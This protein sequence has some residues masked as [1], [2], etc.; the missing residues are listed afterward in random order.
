MKWIDVSKELPPDKTTVLIY[1]RFF[2]A[3]FHFVVY[4]SDNKFIM[5]G[6]EMKHFSH[7]MYLP[8]PPDAKPSKQEKIV[9][10]FLTKKH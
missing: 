6:K 5:D 7:W 3:S 4:F 2:A 9:G 1:S 8:D 10:E